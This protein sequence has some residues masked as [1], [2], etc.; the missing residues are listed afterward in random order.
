MNDEVETY[1]TGFVFLY[2]IGL[3]FKRAIGYKY[4]AFSSTVIF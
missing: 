2:S 4:F 1:D 3:A